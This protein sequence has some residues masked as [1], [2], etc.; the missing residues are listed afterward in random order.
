MN[1]LLS[2][3]P[4][5]LVRSLGGGHCSG[6]EQK[7][8][9]HNE[10]IDEDYW[11]FTIRT[12]TPVSSHS[13]LTVSRDLITAVVCRRALF[14]LFRVSQVSSCVTFFSMMWLVCEEVSLLWSILCVSCIIEQ[15]SQTFIDTASSI[16]VMIYTTLWLCSGLY[17]LIIFMY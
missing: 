5:I 7:C 9:D 13:L 12:H 15:T 14:I 11:I 17:L 1:Y 3:Y 16:I 6:G 4:D 2:H 10:R 8:L